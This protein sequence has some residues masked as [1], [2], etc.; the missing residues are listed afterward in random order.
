MSLPFPPVRLWTVTLP[1]GDVLDASLETGAGGAQTLHLTCPA[2][3]LDRRL[4]VTGL[5]ALTSWEATLRQH[6]ALTAHV[7]LT[8]RTVVDGASAR[9]LVVP[10][11]G[12]AS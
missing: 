3:G 7:T 4:P 5:L 1:N 12:D 9:V 10:G 6:G 8:T 11:P 2:A